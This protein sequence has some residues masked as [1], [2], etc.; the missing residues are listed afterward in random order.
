METKINYLKSVDSTTLIER[1]AFW[2]HEHPTASKAMQVATIVLG[3][4]LIA[5]LPFS[6]PFLTTGSIAALVLTGAALLTA[7]LITTLARQIIPLHHEMNQHV[8]Q[9]AQCEGGKLYY[10]GDVPILSL[11]ADH[12]YL[13]GKAQGYLC[14]DAINRIVKRLDFALHRLE[15]YPRAESLPKTLDAIRQVIPHSYREEMSGLLDGYRQWAKEH[16]LQFP[17]AV[18]ED[19]VLLLQLLPDSLHFN[20]AEFER[21]TNESQGNELNEAAA[22]ACTAIIDRHDARG[23]QFAR[24]MDWPSLGILGTYSLVIHRGYQNGLHKTVEVGI[25]GLIGTLTGMNDRGLALAMNVC[26]GTTTEIR[27]MPAA[28]YNRACLESCADIKELE[29]YMRR[30][31]PLGPYHLTV[32]DRISAQSFH[33]YQAAIAKNQNPHAKRIWKPN[34]PLITLNKC[35]DPKPFGFGIFDDADRQEELDRFVQDRKN[36][37]L[38][39]A[40]AL[41][42]VN[43]WLTTHRVVME[44]QTLRFK[45]AFDNAFAGKAPLCAVPTEKLFHCKAKLPPEGYHSTAG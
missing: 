42:H 5:A 9:P 10:E 12:P 28:F 20:S 37:P 13:A 1:A 29:T 15:I 22:I 36:R 3:I 27:G 19:E 17:K 4:G 34:H 33:F 35:Y 25:P 30:Y 31:A 44:P 16:P 11:D 23:F 8:F 26:L 6:A 18:T 14:G 21:K 41:P 43:N 7:G 24:N 2:F 32:A 39:Q 40:L 45:V 38:E